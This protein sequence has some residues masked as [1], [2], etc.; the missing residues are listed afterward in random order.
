MDDTRIEWIRNKLYSGFQITD[1]NIFEEFLT[2]NDGDNE[3]QL[4]KF[5]NAPCSGEAKSVIFYVLETEHEVE[6]EVETGMSNFLYELCC[7]LYVY[8]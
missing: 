8:V 6:V 4:V 5:L 1:S 2:V 7:I 3:N